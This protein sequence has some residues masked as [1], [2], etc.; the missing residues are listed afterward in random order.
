MIAGLLEGRANHA[1][2]N[3]YISATKE[4]AILQPI[5]VAGEGKDS[6]LEWL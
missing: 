1:C 5:A 6:F 3:N 2:A 4:G